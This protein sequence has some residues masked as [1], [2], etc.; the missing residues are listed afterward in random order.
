MP[1][2]IAVVG[3]ISPLWNPSTPEGSLETTHYRNIGSVSKVFHPFWPISQPSKN[4]V[5]INYCIVWYQ[6]DIHRD[7]Y[8]I[9]WYMYLTIGFI[10]KKAFIHVNRLNVYSLSSIFYQYV[11][12]WM[13]FSKYNILFFV[14]L[15][16]MYEE[17][18]ELDKWFIRKTKIS[19]LSTYVI[20]HLYLWSA[21]TSLDWQEG[22][23]IDD[24]H[25]TD[26]HVSTWY[27]IIIKKKIY[28]SS[29]RFVK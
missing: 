28:P 15:K 4:D 5:C 7:S 16:M 13:I 25:G 17:F 8:V 1:F 27:L 3:Y 12:I 22:Y 20:T 29:I 21:R 10:F 18:L 23:Q 11:N 14:D 19:L 6:S 26:R 2:L 24:C 9:T